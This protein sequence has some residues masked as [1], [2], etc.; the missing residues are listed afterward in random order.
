MANLIVI[1]CSVID[2]VLFLSFGLYVI[3]RLMNLFEDNKKEY[4]KGYEDGTKD[5]DDCIEISYKN[6]WDDC[7][8]Y[9]TEHFETKKIDELLENLER[10]NKRLKMF[11]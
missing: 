9:L 2:I 1:I 8:Q 5:K 11:N 6:G 4:N 3:V 10:D 7:E